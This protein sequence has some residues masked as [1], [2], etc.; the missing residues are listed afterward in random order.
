[1][2]NGKEIA[3]SCTIRAGGFSGERIVQVRLADGTEY[4]GLAPEHYCWDKDRHALAL[5][6]PA[7]GESMPGFVAARRLKNWPSGKTV[8]T[9]PD[10][11]VF[12]VANDII[13]DR[14]AAEITSNVPV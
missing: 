10:G 1:M 14:P 12:A 7:P 13:S 3:L 2:I 11:E 9:T 8:V 4:Q 5:D 6:Q